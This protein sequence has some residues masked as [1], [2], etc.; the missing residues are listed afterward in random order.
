M[1]LKEKVHNQFEQTFHQLLWDFQEPT[2]E[3]DEMFNSFSSNFNSCLTVA[4]EVGMVK[5]CL[6]CTLI[7]IQDSL[8]C[9]LNEELETMLSLF[10]Y[11][12]QLMLLGEQRSFDC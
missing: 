4:Y 2:D 9:N 3:I 6:A 12:L 10:S 5:E 1:S 7:L 11:D 8:K